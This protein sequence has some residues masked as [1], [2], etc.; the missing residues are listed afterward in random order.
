MAKR[1]SERLPI[2]LSRKFILSDET[3][4]AI[5]EAYKAARTNLIFSL[6]S[7]ERKMVVVTSCGPSEGKS[8]NCLNLAITMAETGASV[9]LIDCDMRKPVQHTLLRLDNKIGL[10]SVLGGIVH[11]ISKAINRGVR[12][13]LDVLTAGPIPPNPAELISGSIMDQLLDLASRHY[14][15]VFIDTPPATVVTD[16]LLF[17]SRTAGMIFVVKEGN[18]THGGIHEALEKAKMT[19]GKV[20][21]FLKVN[22]S[23]K[24]GKS[25]YGS[26]KYNYS[27]E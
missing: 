7:S 4:F 19:N 1:K 13:R 24:G 26:Y 14:D 27:Y 6:A 21:G 20:L 9:L 3:Q 10:S 15:Y 11:D 17:N 25:G 22:C 5:R 18:T 8:T 2:S 12:T 23:A 16:A